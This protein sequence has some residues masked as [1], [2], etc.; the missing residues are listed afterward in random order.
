MSIDI[1]IPDNHLTYLSNHA[2]DELVTTVTAYTEDLI[3]EASRL[4]AAS[5]NDSGKPEITRTMIADASL[6]LKKYPAQKKKTWGNWVN[7][8]ISI[9]STLFAG[10]LFNIDKFQLDSTRLVAFLIVLAIAIFTNT[11]NIF[12]GREK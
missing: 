1:K 6:I 2:K 10:A 5:R 11:A 3:S 9:F 8:I 12:I 7:Q 4:E